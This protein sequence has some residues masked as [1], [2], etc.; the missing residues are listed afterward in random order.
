MTEQKTDSLLT[1][2]TVFWSVCVHSMDPFM[3][4]SFSFGSHIVFILPSSLATVK[5]AQI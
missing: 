3:H 2:L 1:R 4:V 5:T